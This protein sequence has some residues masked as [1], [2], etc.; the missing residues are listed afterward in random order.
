MVGQ[1]GA[2]WLSPYRG[3]ETEPK[4]AYSLNMLA[5]TVSR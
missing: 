4:S 3:M 5:R 2:G 1:R